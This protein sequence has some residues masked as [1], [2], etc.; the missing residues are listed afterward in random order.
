[1][2]PTT[3]WRERTAFLEKRTVY[4][5][6]LDMFLNFDPTQVSAIG[7]GLRLRA[8]LR[9]PDAATVEKHRESW[10]QGKARRFWPEPEFADSYHALNEEL[11]TSVDGSTH[12]V[13]VARVVELQD[14]M[15]VRPSGVVELDGRASLVTNDQANISMAYHG[16]VHLGYSGAN[17]L[18]YDGATSGSAR[19]VTLF[20]VDR[21]RYRWLTQVQLVG[22]AEA[23]VYGLGKVNATDK[24]MLLS[25]DFYSAL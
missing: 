15:T 8:G 4:V 13:P 5:F 10:Q 17:R 16:V 20:E 21:P 6:S 11:F 24:V 2:L 23:T 9:D 7:Q 12:E 25:T 14:W 22:F 19:L 18:L 3:D 1:M